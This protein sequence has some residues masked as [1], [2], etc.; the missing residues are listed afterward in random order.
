MQSTSAYHAVQPPGA[1]STW[2]RAHRGW[3]GA[4][5]S[6]KKTKTAQL[7]LSSAHPCSSAHILNAC[8]P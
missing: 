5:Q 4:H 3:A 7:F 2:I 8:A 6:I 1:G